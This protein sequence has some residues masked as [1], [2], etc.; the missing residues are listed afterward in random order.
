MIF[1]QTKKR[2]KQVPFKHMVGECQPRLFRSLPRFKV[3][4]N[5]RKWSPICHLSDYHPNNHHPNPNFIYPYQILFSL[6]DFPSKRGTLKK[7]HVN[8]SLK[9]NQTEIKFFIYIIYICVSIQFG[10]PI[11]HQFSHSDPHVPLHRSPPWRSGC[12]AAAR[13]SRLLGARLR[14]WTNRPSALRL[15]SARC[16]WSGKAGG[17]VWYAWSNPFFGEVNLSCP[18]FLAVK[19]L[20]PMWN[21]QAFSIVNYPMV[22]RYWHVNTAETKTGSK[23]AVKMAQPKNG[24]HIL[25]YIYTHT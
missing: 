24:W 4:Q 17:L 15:W 1:R 2:V 12:P 5:Y 3:I 19:E 7:K 11:P 25:Y 9:I 18:F 10:L 6:L 23:W 20:G 14:R 16:R 8:Q 21:S 13:S 22:Q